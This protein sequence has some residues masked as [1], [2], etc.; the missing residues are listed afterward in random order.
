MMF[1]ELIIGVGYCKGVLSYGRHSHTDS[2]E[3]KAHLK[4]G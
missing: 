1:L 2:F 3:V 4:K